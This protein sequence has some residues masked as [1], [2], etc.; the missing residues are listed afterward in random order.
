MLAGSV[1]IVVFACVVG[2]AVYQRPPPVR[3]VYLESEASTP[4]EMLLRRENCLTCHELFGNGTSYGPSL[5]GVG[6]RR[7]EAWLAGYLRAP[8]AGVG[9]KEYRVRM[10]SY[11]ALPGDEQAALVGYLTA[12]REVDAAGVPVSPPQGG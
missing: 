3:F 9:E 11:A 2:L 7:S 10:P 5:D 6:S 4:G 8:R 1:L 12:L